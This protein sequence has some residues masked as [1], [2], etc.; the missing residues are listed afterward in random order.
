MTTTLDQTA[1]ED[2]L[3][4]SAVATLELYSIHLGRQLGLYP[5][6]AGQLRTTMELAKDAGID[7]RYAR[8]WLEQQAVAGFVVVDDP[9]LPDPER[10]YS[11][12]DSARA[13]F[14]DPEDP[15]HVSPLADMVVGVGQTLAKVVKAYRTGEGVGFA[16][17]GKALR[18]GQGGINRPAFTHDL[19][20]TWLSAIEGLSE[21]LSAGGRIADLGC[22]VGWSTIAMAEAL[23]AAEVTGWDNDPASVEDARRNAADANASVRFEAANAKMMAADGPFDLV[24]ILEALH[25][26]A[27]PVAVLEAVRSGLSAEG[28]VLLADE[29]VAEQFSAPGDEMERMMYG[30]SVTHCLPAAMAEQPSAAIGTVIREPLVRNLAAEA[31]FTSVEVLDVDAGFFRLY[32]L[33]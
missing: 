29:K 3:I 16:E 28:V 31:G 19:A 32:A 23:P 27:Q 12:T 20:T 13:V 21:R 5:A 17:Y 15:A 7:E 2:R 18:D 6:L 4:S 33:R 26:M 24:T 10:R 1:L 22:G 11:L 14:V 9:A 25:D 8:E 30:W